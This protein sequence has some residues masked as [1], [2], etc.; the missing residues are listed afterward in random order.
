MP[1]PPTQLP[2]LFKTN[3]PN[4]FM[5]APQQQHQ[6]Q[7]QQHQQY[8]QQQFLSG[9]NG[10]YNSFGLSSDM[11]ASSLADDLMLSPMLT[12]DVEA[13]IGDVPDLHDAIS[14]VSH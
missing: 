4:H 3:V 11:N 13:G 7:H 9:S 6:F 5:S 8:D 14:I 1:E 10:F 2:S 12:A